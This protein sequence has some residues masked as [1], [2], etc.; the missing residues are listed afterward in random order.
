MRMAH[1]LWASYI[2]LMAKKFRYKSYPTDSPPC[3]HVNKP[4]HHTKPK[5]EYPMA[6]KLTQHQII[7]NH[8]KKVGTITQRDAIVEYSIQSLTKRIQEM[9]QLGYNILSMR[10]RHKV[11]GQLYTRYVYLGENLSA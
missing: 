5:K 3:L 6:K 9:R 7:L 4:F 11:T 2:R 1:A 10:K 8:F